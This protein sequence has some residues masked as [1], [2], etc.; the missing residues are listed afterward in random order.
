MAIQF[1]TEELEESTSQEKKP[2]GLSLSLPVGG[3]RA[4]TTDR[5]FFTE[6]LAL[7]LETGESLFGA[8]STIVKQTENAEMR[9]IV[10]KVAQDIVTL[11]LRKTN[12]FLFGSAKRVHF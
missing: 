11:F 5:M 2:P 9:A 7:L 6:Q 10:E 1:D 12:G 8:L 4:G 3:K